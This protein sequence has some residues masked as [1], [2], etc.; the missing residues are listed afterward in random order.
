MAFMEEAL[1]RPLAEW[2][3]VMQQRIME[4]STY[5]GIA[6][7]KNPL[8]FWVYQEILWESRPDVVVEIGN[9]RGG[10]TLALAH[11]ADL[12]GHGRIVAVDCDHDRIAAEA[13]AHP[14]CQEDHGRPLNR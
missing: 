10:S 7:L 5:H 14:N 8:D 11:M 1:D 4:R 6:T 9:F 2:L 12:A 3:P 13:K